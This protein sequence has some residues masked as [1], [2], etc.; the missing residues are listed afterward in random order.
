MDKHLLL[1]GPLHGQVK[2]LVSCSTLRVPTSRG[3]VVYRRQQYV[4]SITHK[5]FVIFV[6]GE[7]GDWES[8]QVAQLLRQHGL[9]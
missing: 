7:T 4:H 6:H 9:L 1:G 8:W 2:T 5:A 3:E